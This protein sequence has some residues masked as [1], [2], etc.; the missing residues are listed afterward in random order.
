MRLLRR[1]YGTTDYRFTVADIHARS[2]LWNAPPDSG[3]ERGH[4]MAGETVFVLRAKWHA[5]R[6]F[7]PPDMAPLDTLD[8]RMK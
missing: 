5:R 6:G 2:R 7:V 3:V 4:V 1:D 8:A